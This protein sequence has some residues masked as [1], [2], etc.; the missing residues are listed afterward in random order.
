VRGENLIQLSFQKKKELKK[1]IFKNHSERSCRNG[2][3]TKKKPQA[4]G[5]TERLTG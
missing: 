2:E 3:R 1:Q 5:P 4:R